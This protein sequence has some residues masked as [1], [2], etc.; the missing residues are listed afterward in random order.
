MKGFNRLYP[1]VTAWLQDYHNWIEI[2]SDDYRSS[3]IRVLDH[4]GMIWESEKHY[5]TID[6]ALADADQVI[7]DWIA[8]NYSD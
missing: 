7:A 3:M 2:G 4:G 1:H 6:Q 8:A 5:D